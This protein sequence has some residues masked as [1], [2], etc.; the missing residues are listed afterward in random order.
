MALDGEVREAVPTNV[1]VK[2]GTLPR[3]KGYIAGS[4]A[5]DSLDRMIT[6]IES[7]FHPSNTGLWSLSVCGNPT[8]LKN[9]KAYL[10]FL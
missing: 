2:P 10:S 6:S 5:M 9:L 8:N 7:Y 4:K 3:Q 1:R